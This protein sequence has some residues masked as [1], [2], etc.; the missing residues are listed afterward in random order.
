MSVH[1][2]SISNVSTHLV[3]NEFITPDKRD[4][5]ERNKSPQVIAS[6]KCR[7]LVLVN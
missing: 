5:N 6:V 1:Y 7:C 2:Y 3:Y 4:D